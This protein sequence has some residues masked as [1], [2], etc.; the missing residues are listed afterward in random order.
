[1]GS[2]ILKTSIFSRNL[3]VQFTITRVLR[4]FEG[5][6]VVQAP[7]FGA[8]WRGSI[9]RGAVDFL[10]KAAKFLENIEV[11][12]VGPKSASLKTSTT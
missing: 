9:L 7:P 5:G 10:Q 6:S 4:Y 8:V 3:G 12:E 2:I 1:M 11:L